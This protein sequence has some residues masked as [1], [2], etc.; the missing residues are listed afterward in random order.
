[1]LCEARAPVN[2]HTSTTTKAA[3]PPVCITAENSGHSNNTFDNPVTNCTAK[4]AN[5]QLEAVVMART[6]RKAK[7]SHAK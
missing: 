3:A 6:R 2:I 4:H 5:S 1:V 7:A